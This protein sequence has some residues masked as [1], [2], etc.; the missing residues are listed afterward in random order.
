MESFQSARIIDRNVS[1]LD[2]FVLAI[3][4]DSRVKLIAHPVM[5]KMKTNEKIIKTR[6][7]KKR[8]S[9]DNWTGS[10]PCE[11]RGGGLTLQEPYEENAHGQ[12]NLALQVTSP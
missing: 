11:R 10:T 4:T 2:L 3:P 9:T 12:S 7:M 1:N 8:L 6:R 5:K